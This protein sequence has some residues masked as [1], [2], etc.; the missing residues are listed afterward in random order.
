MTSIAL[1][2]LLISCGKGKSDVAAVPV[3]TETKRLDIARAKASQS[4]HPIAGVYTLGEL[5]GEIGVE[6]KLKLK[7]YF[8]I[9]DAEFDVFL[10][11]HFEN[12]KDMWAED[13]G[14]LEFE[15]NQIMNI[16][17]GD[18]EIP[19]L[20]DSE[21]D[22]TCDARIPKNFSLKYDQLE[23]GNLKITEENGIVYMLKRI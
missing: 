12:G 5:D 2:L 23:D 13:S 18:D 11:C 7:P 9:S 22:E 15:E 6:S 16:M 21:G 14:V 1:F 19:V 20:S 3:S 8:V 10:S 4:K 17:G